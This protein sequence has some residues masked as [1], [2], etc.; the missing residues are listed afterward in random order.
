MA[1]GLAACFRQPPGGG[2][3]LGSMELERE[4]WA[5]T[6]APRPPSSADAPRGVG[7]G[8]RRAGG[9]DGRDVGGAVQHSA[10]GSAERSDGVVVY[11]L[12]L[13]VD[14]ILVLDEQ[15]QHVELDDVDDPRWFATV[16]F[17]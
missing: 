13:V 2:R 5:I 3:R 10:L 12:L 7:H 14:L 15:H 17:R 9:R 11:E 6:R 8:P 16:V 4:V 1:A